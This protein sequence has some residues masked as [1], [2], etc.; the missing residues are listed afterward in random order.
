MFIAHE[1]IQKTTFDCP[2]LLFYQKLTVLHD[3]VK[4]QFGKNTNKAFSKLWRP[5]TRVVEDLQLKR[6]AS[7]MDKYWDKL[8]TTGTF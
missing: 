8:F 5:L 2:H 3:M 1:L 6:V 4:A 7:Q